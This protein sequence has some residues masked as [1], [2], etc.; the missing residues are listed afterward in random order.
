V[1][2]VGL[3]TPYQAGPAI[4]FHGR[5]G[6]GGP[7]V[8]IEALQENDQLY[9]RRSRNELGLR[10]TG[11]LRRFPRHNAYAQA[12]LADV[13]AANRL[14][15]ARRFEAREMRSGTYLSQIEGPHRFEA[16]PWEAQLSPLQGMVALDLTGDGA[17]DL[18]A[19]QNSH[20][21]TPSLGRFSGG[22]GVVLVNDGHGRFRA[23][24]PLASGLVVPG[25]AKALVVTDFNH[26][27]WPDL[28]ASRNDETALRFRRSQPVG[29]RPL[30]VTLQGP[31]GNPT[32]IGAHLT[33]TYADGSTHSA[34]ISA[35]SGYYSQSAPA[36]FF[37]FS[38]P[39][40][41]LAVR[42]PNGSTSHHDLTADSAPFVV[43]RQ[44]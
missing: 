30:R 7:P 33:V 2:N 10:I 36:A 29:L 41:G 37:A 3:N 23:L 4:L 43:I 8:I 6:D 5:F 19:V 26:D 13:L 1:G 18:A 32:A 31:V 25:D 22:L 28:V 20:A 39:P 21:P 9:P 16:L 38:S 17:P 15:Q 27:G 44:P 24:A 11:L 42:W 35:G 14:A 34:E 40:R 12:T